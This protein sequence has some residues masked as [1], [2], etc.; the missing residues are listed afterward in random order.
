MTIKENLKRIHSQI[1]NTALVA[2]TKNRTIEEI[3][4]AVNDGVKIIAENRVQEAEQK[5]RQLREFLKGNNVEFHFIGH[6]QTNKVKKAV[7]IFD[8]IQSLDS[9]KLAKKIEKRARSINKVQRVLVQINIG[10]E[11]QKYGVSVERLSDFLKIV[12][13]FTN[14]KVQGL[15]CI[16][17]YFE[18]NEKTRPYFKKMKE[19]FNKSKEDYKLSFLS[20]GMTKDYRVAIQEGS[21]MVRVGG[22]IFNRER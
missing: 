12:S 3:R 1:G 6:L 11:Q 21:N 10:E 9:L 22:G 15:M 18:D 20:M 7:E 4:E 5:H 8:M 14:L 19:L 2:V 17:P 16:T 13:K